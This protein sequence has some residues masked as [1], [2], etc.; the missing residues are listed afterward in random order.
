MKNSS[1]R[2]RKPQDEIAED[3]DYAAALPAK[4]GFSVITGSGDAVQVVPPPPPSLGAEG[5][6]RWQQFCEILIKR[7]CLT[8]DFI[9]AL[10]YLCWLWDRMF[11]LKNA[12]NGNLT[13]SSPRVTRMN[14]LLGE[15]TKLQMLV[16]AVMNDFGLTPGH[17]KGAKV[18]LSGQGGVE[19][20]V[21]RRAR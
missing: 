18:I 5:K 10:E 11:E 14:P 2:G 7:K 8:S 15:L 19:S 4:G 20:N 6:Q 21:R 9:P 13:H 16:R 12:V 17:Y 1:K 3:D